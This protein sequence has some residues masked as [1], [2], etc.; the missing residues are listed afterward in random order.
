MIYNEIHRLRNE[1][2]SNSAIARKLNISRNRVIDYGRMTPEEFHSFALSLQ[3]RQKK[4]DP[5]HLEILKWLKEH[6]DLTGAQVF[7]WL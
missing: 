4:L 3:N 1:G 7:D 6:P 2:F 5:Y